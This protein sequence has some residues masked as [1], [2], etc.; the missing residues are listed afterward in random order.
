MAKYDIFISFKHTDDDGRIT[1]DCEMAESLYFALQKKGYNPFFSKRSIIDVGRSDYIDLINEALEEAKILV[2]VATS[3]ANLTSPWVKR[4]INMFSA[5]MMQEND[6]SRVIIS[7]LSPDFPLKQLPANL[8]DRQFFLDEKGVVY[9]I[10]TSF[11]MASGFRNEDGNTTLL[12]DNNPIPLQASATTIPNSIIEKLEIGDK[13]NGK[14]TILKK[15]GQGGMANVY[16]AISERVNKIY[17]IKEIRKDSALN[18]ETAVRALQVEIDILKHLEHPALPGIFDI[19]DTKD[20]FIVIMEYIKGTTLQT[21]LDEFGAQP[22][23]HVIEIAKQLADVLYYLHSRTI[24]IIYRDVKP[25]NI[26]L[27]PD[28]KIKLIDFGT[29][30]E[31]KQ[32]ALHDTTYLGTVGYAAPEQFGGMG[33]TDCRTDIYGLGVTLYHLVTGKSPA[34]PPYEILPIR[35]INPKLSSGLEYIIQKCTKKDPEQRYQSAS[36][37]MYDLEHIDELG[38][39]PSRFSLFRG[40]KLTELNLNKADRIKAATPEKKPVA[41]SSP[42]T[43]FTL[44]GTSVTVKNNVPVIPPVAKP[45]YAS[46]AELTETAELMETAKLTEAP[47]KSTEPAEVTVDLDSHNYTDPSLEDTLAKLAALD[48]ASQKIITDLIDKL[49]K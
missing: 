23:E 21:V 6:G 16:M 39:K 40:K 27:Q 47:V 20:A 42:I 36:E 26:F 24:P 41:P 45:N 22:E 32:T 38:K 17:A 9:F 34:E 14:Y 30:R 35:Q 7:F 48:P 44:P 29:A 8:S 18:F 43:G 13:L 49:S 4:E 5:M 2:A 37:L 25:A 28:S 3:R 31:Y 12:Y 33:Q 1:K 11:N 10:D 46:T 19:I 15:I